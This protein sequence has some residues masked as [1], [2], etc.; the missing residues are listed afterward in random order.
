[1]FGLT[2]TRKYRA[3]QQRQKASALDYLLDAARY[4][5]RL[6]RLAAAHWN[7][8]Q[9]AA[10]HERAAHHLARERL[11]DAHHRTHHPDSVPAGSSHRRG[12]EAAR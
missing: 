8:R 10:R 3:L 9:E 4:E 1:M 12:Q 5:Q 6:Q 7:L 2:T 11:N